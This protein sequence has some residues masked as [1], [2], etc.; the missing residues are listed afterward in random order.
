MIPPRQAP[1]PGLAVLE[2]RRGNHSERV[3]LGFLEKDLRARITAIL[4]VF[5]LISVG[6]SLAI[7][8]TLVTYIIRDNVRQSMLDA[9][10]LTRNVVE[11]ALERRSTRMELLSSM[12]SMRDPATSPEVRAATLSLFVAN[13]PIGQDILFSDTNGNV[14]CGTGKL[15]TLAS[16]SGTSWFE[17]ALAGGTTF[18]Y[19]G[20]TTELTAAFFKSPVLAVSSSVRDV[21]N[22][23]FGYVVGFTNT[24]DITTAVR[25]V[26]VETTGHGFLVSGTGDI[27]AGRLFPA[28]LKPG[29]VDA[30]RY[31]QLLSRITRGQSGQAFISYGGRGY[32]VAWMPVETDQAGGAGLDCSV[33]VAVPTAEAYQ[34]ASQVTLAL[35]LLGLVLFVL[36]IVA[37][38]LL[39]RSITRPINELVASAEKVGS[40]DLTGDIA[41]RTRDQVGKLAA[42]FLRMRDYMRGALAEA[43]YAADRMST[44]ADEQSAGTGDVFSNTEEIVESVVVLAKNME[45]LTQR[46]RK[47]LEYADEVPA[48]LRD[49]PEMREARDVLQSCEIL[50]EV[51]SNKAIEIASAAQDQRGAARDVAAAAR[52][53]SDMARELKTMVRK[54][55]V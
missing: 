34:P 32:L 19:I 1:G 21:K 48:S 30:R 25:S 12:P 7:S 42:A 22:Q 33:G 2:M 52:R 38:V 29:K 51:G 28:G 36:G 45:S 37:A 4:L 41:I 27:V 39:G 20:N 5:I 49:T 9:A 47:V 8:H 23:I 14:I 26:M 54:F 6:A 16:A 40:G 13:W 11:V 43:G 50:A 31:E 3:G 18:T 46:L 24:S 17:N 15:S 55:K 53:L 10:R 44:L 35:L